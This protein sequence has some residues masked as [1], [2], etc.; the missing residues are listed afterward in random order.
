MKDTPLLG[1]FE[2]V[3]EPKKIPEKKPKPKPEEPKEAVEAVQEP[4]PKKEQ[5]PIPAE[6]PTGKEL[7]P[8]ESGLMDPGTAS[9][10]PTT[11]E[12]KLFL[13]GNIDVLERYLDMRNKEEAR[14]ARK[15][16][17]LHFAEMQKDLVIVNRETKG[18]NA[19]YATL[20]QLIAANGKTIS[21]HGFSYRW[22]KGPSPDMKGYTRT[23][24]IITG[25]GHTDEET[26]TDLPPLDEEA[27]KS[28]KTMNNIQAVLAVDTYAKRATFAA[29]FGIA[30]KD[31][32]L[33]SAIT[34]DVA[35]KLTDEVMVI[36]NAESLEQLAADYK[37]L[38]QPFHQKKMMGEFNYLSQIK[39][40]RK[41]EL[42]AGQQKTGA[43]NGTTK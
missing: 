25:W 16:F 2:V 36:K 21:N 14:N 34:P 15:E 29:G 32:D 42:E 24:L 8:V 4:E 33:D 5:E 38:A 26:F 41:K 7:T 23:T 35:M 28:M 13:S 20:E 37:R 40:A 30:T 1:E 19:D 11:L 6:L 9:F 22:K 18:Y 17:D 10:I 27:R 12:E 31:K 3:E 39:D 43:T